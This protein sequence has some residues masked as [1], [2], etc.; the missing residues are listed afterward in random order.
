MP[1]RGISNDY[2]T[3]VED[4]IAAIIMGRYAL[5][6]LEAMVVGSMRNSQLPRCE[7][8]RILQLLSEIRRAVDLGH[9]FGKR[10]RGRL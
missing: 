4:Q 2:L 5:I 9:E 8:E 1:K 3:R 7:Q 6:D 10:E